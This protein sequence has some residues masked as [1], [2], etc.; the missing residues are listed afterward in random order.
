LMGFGKT[1]KDVMDQ[2]HEALLAVGRRSNGTGRYILKANEMAALNLLMELHDAQLDIIT[3][4]DMERAIKL[5]E[6][7][8]SA[9]RTTPIK[10]TKHEPA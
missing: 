9:G 10:E 6:K 2:G 7:E 8:R 5:V 4:K 1:Y 3:V